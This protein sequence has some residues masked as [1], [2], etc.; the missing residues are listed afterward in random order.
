MYAIMETGGQQF[1]V[2]EGDKVRVPKLELEPKK[3]FTIEKI[4]LIGG[5]EKPLI[6]APYVQGAKIEAQVT[7]HGKSDK[8]VVFKFK[9][10]VKYRRKKGH[11]QLYTEVLIKKINLPKS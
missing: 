7:D 11:R 2:Q 6:G 4:L 10:R 1:A 9:K 3:N 8:V 5:Q